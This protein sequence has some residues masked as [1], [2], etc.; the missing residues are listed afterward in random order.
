MREK[1]PEDSG[2]GVV[3]KH[4]E[5]SEVELVN[6]LENGLGADGRSCTG[7]VGEA[8]PGTQT[9]EELYA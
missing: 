8:R 5:A 4:G 1:E 9:P 7:T 3:P 2:I 6:R